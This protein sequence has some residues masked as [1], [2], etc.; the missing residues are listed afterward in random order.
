VKF[1]GQTWNYFRVKFMRHEKS[2]I[3]EK[4][5]FHDEFSWS[6]QQKVQ[7]QKYKLS[8]TVRGVSYD[9]TSMKARKYFSYNKNDIQLFLRSFS[10][11]NWP[12][13]WN[14]PVSLLQWSLSVG[15]DIGWFRCRGEIV[16]N[17]VFNFDLNKNWTTKNEES[18]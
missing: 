2:M 10:E 6:S 5:R 15:T 13:D 11:F 16:R 7:K 17:S 4:F 1:K 18:T 14:N 8:K 9:G 12:T 3:R